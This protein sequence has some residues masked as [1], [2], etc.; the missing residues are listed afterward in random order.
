MYVCAGGA[1]VGRALW[2]GADA[3]VGIGAV[4]TSFTITTV[5]SVC[6]ALSDV[7]ATALVALTAAV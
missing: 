3:N 2:A 6:T 5:D 4:E 1:P 7:R